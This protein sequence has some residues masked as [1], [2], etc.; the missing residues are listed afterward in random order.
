MRVILKIF[1][2]PK[3]SLSEGINFQVGIDCA[4]GRAYKGQGMSKFEK[5]PLAHLVLKIASEKGIPWIFSKK[6]L[7]NLEKL[8]VGLKGPTRMHFVHSR[9]FG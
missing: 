8:L 4:T 2:L 3:K 6:C 7:K 5:S 1:P 9:D